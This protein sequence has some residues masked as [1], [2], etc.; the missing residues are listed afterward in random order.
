MRVI[1]RYLL[2]ASVCDQLSILGVGGSEDVVPWSG[3]LIPLAEDLGSV[4]STHIKAY[5]CL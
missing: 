3:A 2:A 5:N 4:P 1:L